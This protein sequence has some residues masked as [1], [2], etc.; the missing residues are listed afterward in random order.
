MESFFAMA[1]VIHIRDDRYN[2]SKI[3]KQPSI[4]SRTRDKTPLP[5]PR[6]QKATVQNGEF[7]ETLFEKRVPSCVL[8]SVVYEQ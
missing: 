6:S 4:I 5:V 8:G 7:R 1:S 2:C 3:I